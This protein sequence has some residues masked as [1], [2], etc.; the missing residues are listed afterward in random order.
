MAILLNNKILQSAEAALESNLMP[1]VKEDYMKIVVA[2]MRAALHG[3]TEGLLADRLRRSKDPLGDIAKG[4]VNLVMALSHQ[5]KGVM[6]MKA[7]GPASMTLM[8]QALDFAD[9]A[10]VIKVGAAE[11]VKA[12]HIWANRLMTAL[13]ITPAM[14][15]KAAGMAHGVMN[16]PT[17]VEAIKRR[18]GLVKDPRASTPTALAE[19]GA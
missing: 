16:D 9:K 7:M 17:Q 15:N 1:E 8:L 14:L 18:A 5:S 4:A 6:P 11:L 12:T 19:P 13:H 2:G 3:G 10:G